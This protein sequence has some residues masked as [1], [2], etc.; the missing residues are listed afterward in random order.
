[1]QTFHHY[2][3]IIHK[4]VNHTQRLCDS[5]AG[6]VLSQSVQSLKHSLDLALSEQFLCELFYGKLRDEQL[7][8]DNGLTKPSLSDL[9][10]RQGKHRK[11][12]DDYFDND[13]CHYWG[14]RNVGVDVEA[15][16]KTAQAL[17]EIEKGVIA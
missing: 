7:I 2:S 14:G 9:F 6:L 12:L 5:D 4:T 16:E 11:Y 15:F 8:H 3:C 17:E 1:M 13:V 10:C